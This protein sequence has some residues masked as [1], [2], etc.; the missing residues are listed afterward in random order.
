MTYFHTALNMYFLCPAETESSFM[1][2]NKHTECVQELKIGSVHARNTYKSILPT[3]LCSRFAAL[4]RRPSELDCKGFLKK[5]T[6]KLVYGY[7][8]SSIHREQTRP[9]ASPAQSHSQQRCLSEGLQS[10]SEVVCRKGQ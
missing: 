8:E 7:K 6:L 4:P 9:G 3:C 10:S 1:E 5:P 2:C